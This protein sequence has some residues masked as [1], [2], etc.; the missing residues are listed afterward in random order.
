MKKSDIEVHSDRGAGHPAINVKY[1]GNG[2]MLKEKVMEQFKCSEPCA[3]KALE[4]AWNM[5]QRD[6]WED[7]EELVKD[8]F[9]E[10]KMYSEG[11]SGGWLTVHGLPDVDTW[12]AIMVSRWSK[13]DKGIQNSMKC[14]TDAKYILENIERNQW[15][16]DGSEEYNFKELKDG[17]R[18]CIAEMKQEAIKAGF[19][20]VVRR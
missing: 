11:R 3:E 14:F 17:T 18:I 1:H 6:F 2:F 7:A 13:L 15:Y 4:Y 8:I 16:L 10:G 5:A 19:G 20:A 9:P 12:D